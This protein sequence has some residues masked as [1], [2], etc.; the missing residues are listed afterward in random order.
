MSRVPEELLVRFFEGDLSTV[1]ESAALHRIAEDRDARAQLRFELGLR[2]AFAELGAA[3]PP[4]GFTERVMTA[5]G[6]GQSMGAD[7]THPIG[8]RPSPPWSR[9]KRFL[10]PRTVHWHPAHALLA[11]AGTAVVVWGVL[12]LGIFPV[13]PGPA[14]DLARVPFDTSGADTVLVRFAF[15]DAAA[16]SVAVAGDFSRWTPIPLAPHMQDGALVWVGVVPVPRGEHRY[17]FVVDGDRWVTDPLAPVVRDDG[18]G[19]RNAILSL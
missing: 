8:A 1:D 3:S 5:C 9:W 14:R 18:F 19:N 16:G 13:A 10:R 11:L 2:R 12:A 17:M 6:P 7:T 4:E 15:A